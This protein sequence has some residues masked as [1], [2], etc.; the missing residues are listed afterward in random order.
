MGL[1]ET[2]A[3]HRDLDGADGV[4]GEALVLPEFEE[5]SRQAEMKT[6]KLALAQGEI[7]APA[8]AQGHCRR[9]RS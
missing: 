2:A 1:G 8:P 9:W 6:T 3:A 5:D 4:V 7:G